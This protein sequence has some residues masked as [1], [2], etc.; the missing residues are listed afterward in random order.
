MSVRLKI[1]LIVLPLLVATLVLSSLASSLAARNGITRVAVEFLAFKAQDLR[2]YLESQWALL[3]SN[4]LQDR[5]EYVAAAQKAAL[6]YAGT[7]IGAPTQ[8]ILAVDS[9]GRLA[10]STSGME[11]SARDSATLLDLRRGQTEG[12][13]ELPLAGSARVGHAF[14]FAPFGWYCLVT[15]ERASFFSA[16]SG[17]TRQNLIIL[18]AACAASI[19]L[20]LL[21]S[22]YLTHPMRRMVAAMQ[23]IISQHDLSQRVEVRYQDE[24]GTLAHTFN[25]T[26]DE[27]DQAYNQLKKYALDA[28]VAKRREQDVRNIFQKYVPKDV[29]ESIFKHPEQL[30]VGEDRLAAVLFSDIR[31]F[32][33]IAERMPPE[34][35]V[36]TLN[37]Y[38]SIMVD[39]IMKRGGIVDKYMGDAIMAFFGAPVQHDD[40]ALQAVLAALDMQE[41]LE[42]FNREQESHGK[43]RFRIGIGI[44]FGL[45]TVG[46][47]GSEKKMEYTVIGD[48]VNLAARLESLTKVYK[49]ELIFSESVYREVRKS[50]PCRLVDKVIVLGRSQ[51]H[52]IFTASRTQQ[53]QELEAWK[54]HHHGLQLYY[55][56]SFKRAATCF[57]KV[58]D[59]LPGDVLSAVY[60]DRCTSFLK[61]PPP[62]AWDGVHVLT[63]K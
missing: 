25:V 7:L 21:F 19:V 11:L 14:S 63:E 61:S 28:V 8:L 16:V 4:G 52:R 22:G 37:A 17:I 10:M 9:Q 5:P 13:L 42:G 20:L 50:L 12:W 44:N 15:E 38:F 48:M 56:R 32:T 62:A 55:R 45:V 57:R 34:E 59:L 41:A 54:Y 31:G 26:V 49:Q 53:E 39:I 40:D 3:L 58:Q 60:Y 18:A 1:V 35:M 6:S 23:T 24:L 36:Q 47:I 29:I 30:L 2:N 33:A 27:L 51:P 43:P 46:N